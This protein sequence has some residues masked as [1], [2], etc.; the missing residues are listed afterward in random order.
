VSNSSSSSFIVERRHLSDRQLEKLVEHNAS[1][2]DGDEW[3]IHVND[4]VIVASTWMDNFD[5][6][7]YLVGTLGVAAEHVEQG[8]R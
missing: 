2:P 3:E 4:R 7:G 1:A 8:D 5:L 6:Y